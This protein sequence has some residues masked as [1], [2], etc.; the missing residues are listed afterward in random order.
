[1]ERWS[2]DRPAS[3][4]SIYSCFQYSWL[5]MHVATNQAQAKQIHKFV[6]SANKRCARGE[7]SHILPASEET[8]PSERGNRQMT[9]GQKMDGEND[10]HLSLIF[11][12]TTL[13]HG[14]H[15]GSECKCHLLAKHFDITTWV[16]FSWFCLGFWRTNPC[17]LS[18][19]LS[20][21]CRD[22]LK[23]K[24]EFVCVNLT[25]ILVMLSLVLFV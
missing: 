25:T 14:S 24:Y 6:Q 2:K 9:E 19:W 11:N 4:M 5:T 17:D 7:N 15:E 16:W 22:Y 8:R 3:D 18:Y 20:E 13:K 21:K 23:N 10:R 1:M 12:Q